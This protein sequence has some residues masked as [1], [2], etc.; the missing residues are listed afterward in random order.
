MAIFLPFGNT[1]SED[2]E[3]ETP[4]STHLLHFKAFIFL[5]YENLE[6]GLSESG[7]FWEFREFSS[8]W[9][10]FPWGPFGKCKTKLFWIWKDP[11]TYK[12]RGT[13]R[14]M[15]P[16]SKETHPCWWLPF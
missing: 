12:V 10:R 9:G 13:S 1:G 8:A 15:S 2:L 14:K 11:V 16:G 3:G 4:R 6:V 5:S 7:R